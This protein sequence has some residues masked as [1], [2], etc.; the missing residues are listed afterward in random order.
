MDGAKAGAAV[1][2]TAGSG[3]RAPARGQS[4]G[5]GAQGPATSGGWHG[6][7]GPR[8]PIPEPG[9]GDA[10]HGECVE[11]GRD[12]PRDPSLDYS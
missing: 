2:R 7:T 11:P 9:P 3:A 1:P 10:D 6:G 5:S 8:I 12:G 4:P